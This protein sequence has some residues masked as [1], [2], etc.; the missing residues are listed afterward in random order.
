MSTYVQVVV[1]V[2]NRFNPANTKV[3]VK[4][5]RIPT[6]LVE[7]GIQP[8]LNDYINL[9]Y[10]F[11]LLNF[12]ENED[13]YLV[14]HATIPEVVPMEGMEFVTMDNIH[15]DDRKAISTIRHL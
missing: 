2:P 7:N 10:S 12:Y 15:E 6:H 13:T 9:G 4:N 11:L 3:M 1:L 5:G 14:F 8:I